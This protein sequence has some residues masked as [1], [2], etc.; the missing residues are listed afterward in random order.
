MLKKLYDYLRCSGIWVTIVV[1]PFHWQFDWN[2]IV[3]DELSGD[4]IEIKLLFLNI[5][6]V[7]DDCEW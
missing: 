1:N 6:I 5:V 3:K 7:I 2:T 4:R